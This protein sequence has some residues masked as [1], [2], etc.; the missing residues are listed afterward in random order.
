MTAPA[1]PRRTMADVREPI[2]VFLIGMRINRLRSLRAWLPATNAMGPM[3]REL[4]AQPEL[5]MLG[6]KTY[7]SGRHITL[8]TYWR[9]FEDLERYARSDDHAHRPAWTAFYRRS[10]A[11]AG[12][13]GIWHE[14]YTVAPGAAESLYVNMPAGFGLGGAIGTIPVTGALDAA[15]RRRDRPTGPGTDA[16]PAA[17]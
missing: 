13:V 9:S 3:F 14:T 16:E 15:R 6:A 1:I 8:V 4:L 12:V 11:A 7:W 2:T 5:G 17:A 10:R